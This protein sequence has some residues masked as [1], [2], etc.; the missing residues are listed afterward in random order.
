MVWMETGT[1]NQF[2]QLN[3][4]SILTLWAGYTRIMV[5]L[6]FSPHT[7]L[8]V[9]QQWVNLVSGLKGLNYK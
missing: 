5:I 2:F 1:H 7:G 3:V 4:L 6:L 9:K 8:S